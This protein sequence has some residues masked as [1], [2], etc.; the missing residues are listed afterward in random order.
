MLNAAAKIKPICWEL[1]ALDS[2]NLGQNGDA[3]PNA[4]YK[5]A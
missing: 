2:K 3:T 5:A 4:A 1:R